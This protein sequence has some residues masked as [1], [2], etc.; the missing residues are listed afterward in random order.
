MAVF[1]GSIYSDALKMDTTLHAVL[2]GDLRTE[3][4]CKPMLPGLK[5]C[6]EMARHGSIMCH[7]FD[8][9]SSTVCVSFYRMDIVA[10]T[11]T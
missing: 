11:K 6:R 5:A 2:T 1:S 3:R 10:F 4:G 8:L 7:C 9:Q